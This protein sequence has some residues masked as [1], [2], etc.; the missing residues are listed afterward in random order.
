MAHFIDLRKLYPLYEA[1]GAPIPMPKTGEGSEGDEDMDE[2]SKPVILKEE[3]ELEFSRTDAKTLL[4]QYE[5]FQAG[6]LWL[7][8]PDETEDMLPH[9]MMNDKKTAAEVLGEL[10]ASEVEDELYDDLYHEDQEIDIEGEV[11][12]D[13]LVTDPKEVAEIEAEMDRQ[14][15]PAADK[16]RLYLTMFNMGRHQLAVPLRPDIQDS[17]FVEAKWMNLAQGMSGDGSAKRD[18]LVDFNQTEPK[19]YNFEEKRAYHKK[20]LQDWI[21]H[22]EAVDKEED[23]EHLAEK[24]LPYVDVVDE[25]GEEGEEGRSLATTG[26]SEGADDLT[27]D[28]EEEYGEDEDDDDETI[29]GEY[30]VNME[31]VKPYTPRENTD[32]YIEYRDTTQVEAIRTTFAPS[33]PPFLLP[34]L[35]FLVSAF[36][37]L[38]FLFFNIFIF[39]EESR[40][41]Y[42]R[43]KRPPLWEDLVQLLELADTLPGVKRGVKKH[44]IPL[45]PKED[46][47]NTLLK[48]LNK[49]KEEK[50][51]ENSS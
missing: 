35:F 22:D 28:Y 36:V 25:E 32:D 1:S 17:E 45:A 51:S 9:L 41:Q 46:T 29:L 11:D 3:K 12:P 48:E 14:P 30:R 6:A 37:C 5:L 49:K 4:K 50:A 26:E 39:A 7:S 10:E 15:L 18:D 34:P 38:F 42:N 16:W 23:E 31:A 27:D 47:F 44:L 19:F 33:P 24:R 20:Q 8:N 2:T 21:R 40:A 13:T 43:S